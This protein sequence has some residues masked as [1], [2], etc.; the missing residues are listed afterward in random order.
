MMN[1]A[2]VK[3]VVAGHVDDGKST[4]IGRLLYETDSLPDGKLEELNELSAK[5]GMQLEWS[6]VLDA[7][8]AERDQ[9]ITIDTT[10]IRLKTIS[11]E[12]VIID[13]PGHIEFLKNMISGAANADAALLLVDASR[14]VREQTRRHAYLLHFLGIKQITVL[15]NK[16]DL[17]DFS[18][19]KFNDLSKQVDQYLKEVGITS[20]S[21][22][23]I[24]GRHGDFL[25]TRSERMPWYEGPTVLDT[26]GYFIRQTESHDGPLR[27]PVQ[28]IYKFDDRRIIVGK[29]E[30]GKL[31]VGDTILVSPSNQT[32][33]I[34][35]IEGWN[36]PTKDSALAH[37]SVGITLNKP[38]FIERG[39]MLSHVDDAPMITPIFKATLFWLGKQPLIEDKLYKMKIS[40]RQVYVSVQTIEYEINI[41]DLSK[42]KTQRIGTN[43]CG[44]VV[45]KTHGAIALDEYQKIPATGR[46]VLVDDDEIVA[47]GMIEMDN[48][49]DQRQSHL[50]NMKHLTSVSHHILQE[51][52]IQ[53]NGHKPGILWF[54]GLSGSGKS[55]L[56]MQLELALFQK[57]YQ[58]Y[59]LDGDNIRHGLK[60]ISGFHRKTELKILPDRRSGFFVCRC[61]IYLYHLFHLPLR[62]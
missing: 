38:L 18:E 27:L 62:V 36:S 39:D 17:I 43:G 34:E 33:R 7:F 37:Q 41:D 22:I 9:A 55:T 47:G 49:V 56:A 6:F 51:H 52:R 15:I 5:R 8:Q 31:S 23:P 45:L 29:I 60:L 28:D 16:M 40:T 2:P 30:S 57:G 10:Q 42:H 19:E 20:C 61:R 14:D 32:A 50:N 58:V 53:R 46:F 3:V 54:T 25:R 59:T 12:I 48:Y 11:G 44:K 1:T 21:I 4:L 24:S 35:S 26:L 13:A